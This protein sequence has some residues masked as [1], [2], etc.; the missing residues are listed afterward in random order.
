MGIE[1]TEMR[2]PFGRLQEYRFWRGATHR[3]H[4]PDLVRSPLTNYSQFM[5][6]LSVR[7][8]EIKIWQLP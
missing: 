1:L 5:R 3:L 6:S 8:A 4:F 2:S 7:L